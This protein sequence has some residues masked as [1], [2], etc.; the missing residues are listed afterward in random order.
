MPGNTDTRIVQM[1][2]DNKDFE[3]N[4]KTSSKSLDKF[5]EHLD[6]DKYEKGLSNLSKAANA[7]SFDNLVTNVQKLTDKFTGLGTLSELVLSQIRRGIESTARKIS[8]MVNSL[9]FDQ[10]TAGKNKFEEMNKNVQTIIGATG[11]S[12]SD[13]YKVMQRLNK[14]TDQTSYNF[15]DMAANIGKFTAVGIDLKQAEKQMEGI[16]NWAAR[17][18][19]GIAEASR[20]MYNL[21]QAMGVGKMTTIDW[22]SIENAGMATKEFKEQ[23]IQAGLAAGTLVL[24]NK[25]NIKTAKSLGKQV[26]VNYQNLRETLQKG[27][28]NRQ[29]MEK[30]LLKYYY[31]DLE[32]DGEKLL[33]LTKKQ[34]EENTKLFQENGKIDASEWKKFAQKGFMTNDVKQGLLDIAAEEGNLVKTTDKSG[35]TIYK[36]AKKYGKE[37][38]VTLDN[39]EESIKMG[40]LDKTVAGN[41][42]IIEGLAEASYKAAQKCLTLTDVFNAWKDQLSTGWM[43]FWQKIFGDL[44]ESMELFSN[45]CNK[46]GES[47]DNFITTLVG[48]GDKLNGV[49]G[50]WADLGGRNSLWSLFV[51]EYDGMYEGA[52]GLLDVFKDIGKLISDGFWMMVKMMN[53]D[54]A[55][56]SDEDWLANEQY[57]TDVLGQKLFDAT[58]KVKDFIQG[59][60][61]FFNAVPAGQTKTRF[62]QIQD[63]VNGVSATA[64]IV[65]NTVSDVIDFFEKLFDDQHLGPAVDDIIEILSYFGME[66]RKTAEETS[67]GEGIGTFLTRLLN[68]FENEG[69]ITAI[70]NF[71]EAFKKLI[72]FILGVDSEKSATLGLWSTISDGLAT[73][74]EHVAKF[75]TPIIDFFTNFLDSIRALASGEI[76]FSDFIGRIKGALK[77]MINSIFDFTPDFTGSIKNIWEKIKAVFTSGFSKESIEELTGS[78]T[79]LF[80]DFKNKI[81]DNV[82]TSLK[83]IYSNVKKFFEDT[84]TNIKNF[85]KPFYDDVKNVFESGFS[86]ESF[87]RLK[88]R[89]ETIFKSI[90]DAIPQSS[91]DSVNNIV[92]KVKDFFIRIW[93]KIKEKF[94]SIFS[95]NKASKDLKKKGSKNGIVQAAASV[96]EGQVEEADKMSIFDRIIKWLSDGFQKVKD[97]I[98]GLF[99]GKNNETGSSAIQQ[100]V[101]AVTGADSKSKIDDKRNIFERIIDWFK[102]KIAKV[103]EFIQRLVGNESGDKNTLIQK[104]KDINFS[105]ILLLIIG[106]LGVVGIIKTI[107]GI[108]K[109][110]KSLAGIAKT[111]SEIPKQI[112]EAL[113]GSPQQV[114][115]KADMILKIAIA[116][117]IVAAAIILVGNM[118]WGD[119]AKGILAMMFVAGILVGVML[120]FEKKFKKI[121]NANAILQGTKGMLLAAASILL[122]AVAFKHIAMIPWNDFWKGIIG[123]AA[124]LGALFAIGKMVQ[125]GISFRWKSM[126]GILAFSLSL[127]LLAVSLMLFG[128]MKTD[129]FLSGL[130]KMGAVLAVLFIFMKAVNKWGGGFNMANTG[131]KEIMFL[132]ISVL[133]LAKA[134]MPLAKL[135]FEQLAQ[136]VGA[137]GAIL[138]MLFLFMKFTKSSTMSSTAMAQFIALAG[139]IVLLVIALLPLTLVD[140]LHLALAVGSVMFLI[141]MLIMVMKAVEGTT[142][143]KGTGMAQLLALAG[144]II[145]LVIAMIPLALLRPE[146]LGQALLGVLFL[147]GFLI[148]FV[149][150]VNSMSLKG[151]GMVQL[152]ALSGAIVILV[153]SMIPLSLMPFGQLAQAVGAILV[154]MLGMSVILLALSKMKVGK[155]ALTNIALLISLSA[156]IYVFALALDKIRDIKLDSIKTFTIMFLALIGGMAAALLALSLIK[157]PATLIATVLILLAGMAAAMLLLSA[158]V[159]VMMDAISGGLERMMTRLALVAGMFGDFANNMDQISESSLE[160]TKRKFEKLMDIMRSVQG[161]GDCIAYVDKFSDGIFSLGTSVHQFTMSTENVG[162]PKTNN[163]IGFVEK[164]LSFK[165]QFNGFTIGSFGT[166]VG[167]LGESVNHFA[168]AAFSAALTM[169]VALMM[170]EN[171]T[172]QANNLD[173]LANLPMDKLRDNLAGLGGA[174]QIYA[175]GVSESDGLNTD[176]LPDIEKAVNLMHSV[177]ASLGEDGGFSSLPDLPD[178]PSLA[179]FGSEL[180]ALATALKL[181]A[182][183]SNGLGDTTPALGVLSFMA[184]LRGRLTDDMVKVANVFGDNKVDLYALTMFGLEIE[185][186]GTSLKNFNKSTEG[187]TRSKE[188]ED[189]LTFFEKLKNKLNSSTLT[190]INEFSEEKISYDSLEIFAQDIAKLGEALSGFATNVNFDDQKSGKFQEGL[191]ALDSLG[192]LANRLPKIGGFIGI[193]EGNVLSLNQLADDTRIL[194]EAMSQFSNVLEGGIGDKS[195]FNAALVA[196]AIES[197]RSIADIALMM[198]MS[199]VNDIYEAYIYVGNLTNFINALNDISDM[200]AFGGVNPIADGIAKFMKEIDK[201][202]ERVG[203]VKDYS[204]FEAFKNM[205]QGIVA[206]MKVD[207]SLDFSVVGENIS[208]G[209]IKGINYKHDQAVQAI[210]N[211]VADVI[212]GAKKKADEHSPSRVFAEIGRF[213]VQGLTKGI[214]DSYG[215]KNGYDPV[216]SSKNM[217]Q[218]TIDAAKAAAKIKSPSREFMSIGEYIGAGLAIGIENSMDHVSDVI[219]DGLIASID[220]TEDDVIKAYQEYS[221]SIIKEGLNMPIKPYSIFRRDYIDSYKN[222]FSPTIK[223][224]KET[225]LASASPSVVNASAFRPSEIE[226]FKFGLQLTDSIIKHLADTENQN[227][228]MQ[229][230]QNSQPIIDMSRPENVMA[231]KDAIYGVGSAGILATGL[232]LDSAYASAFAPK[233]YSMSINAIKGEVEKMRDDLRT[234]SE[235]MSR[236][237]FVFNSGSVVAA[238]GPEMDQYLAEQGYYSVRGEMG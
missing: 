225:V 1:Q 220:K 2:F 62:Q 234:L 217:V 122:V 176:E 165:D 26:E 67:K 186:L 123:I 160:A 219:N 238:I 47:F 73:I 36:T 156:V 182:D 175:A 13:V 147:I 116:I 48:D 25:G 132:A 199:D 233:D 70:N 72:G 58:Q 167:L 49:F 78:V 85:F 22:K 164:I 7:L 69:L 210:I 111:I 214:N 57:R 207:P 208:L 99:T 3:K 35:K 188:A 215:N 144:A 152:L 161:A 173:T 181:F 29:V 172:N 139:A 146:Q 148:L 80:T 112:N 212:D 96:I 11:K 30:T 141:A 201:A 145:M 89:F 232:S 20:A 103:R 130:W 177:M 106:G 86:Q 65:Y 110:V 119:A 28:A 178:E 75:A 101:D 83:T 94:I 155:S 184:E 87:D 60:K 113:H 27:W 104:L 82:K 114:E 209:I 226:K 14:Y 24:D 142:G 21:S 229:T 124:C 56:V 230:T 118:E 54:L 121:K 166:E 64:V 135:E 46:V 218:Q 134:L 193:I 15:T 91:K 128:T 63:V 41:A 81:P 10:I 211:L 190:V 137:I 221:D 9:G 77:T 162:D 40:W 185:A 150:A 125:K 140:Q 157:D 33:D 131:M 107:K 59:I 203:G 183:T 66:L 52:Y 127:S 227:I 17:S 202:F 5:K 153:L 16:A 180:A 97:Y 205:A 43:K 45:I 95:G 120:F 198:A 105:R 74:A 187:F 93:E 223:D 149:Q 168:T 136:G 158:L 44:S 126:S 117:G 235:A 224:Q 34:L 76:T 31:E 39:F 216:E 154:L 79:S 71:S 163:G 133:L 38:E 213:M 171:L 102:D 191:N 108:V 189:A 159:P 90:S 236:T 192:D 194:G 23:L 169:P 32:Y 37:I 222:R 92:Q 151:S 195:K 68:I 204:V 179:A 8:G 200:P 206:L 88:A 228:T 6:F 100:Y 115:T 55:N 197:I 138:L 4:I 231:L 170:L 109:A 237:K 129:T 143:M 50:T 53:P 174:L 61:D 19:A 196:S 18:G 42:G 84:W 12:E 98:I 51:G